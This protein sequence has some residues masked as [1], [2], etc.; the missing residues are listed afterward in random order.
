MIVVGWTQVFSCPRP[1][2]WGPGST[3]K[4]NAINRAHVYKI[5]ENISSTYNELHYKYCKIPDMANLANV[6]L[7]NQRHVG[8]H[9]ER[10][11][12]CQAR[13]LCEHVQVPGTRSQ[14]IEVGMQV[15]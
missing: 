13:R 14:L 10:H 15:S 12:A 2:S 8:R 9:G 3:C 5:L 11:L 1:Q 7:H 6:V 4:S